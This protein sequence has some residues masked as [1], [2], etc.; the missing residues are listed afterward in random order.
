MSL[1]TILATA[2]LTTTGFHIKA[3]GTTLGNSLIWD[4]GTNVGIGNT[5]TSYTLD[6]SGTGRFTSTLLVSGAATFS[7]TIGAGGTITIPSDVSGTSGYK[8]N[9]TS[10][11]AGS[12][13]WKIANDS[14]AY[15]DFVIQQSTTQSGSTYVNKFII[16]PSGN[17]GIGVTPSNGWVNGYA[18]EVG[19]VGNAVWGR[20]S[21]EFH[22]T[23]NY[24][25]SAS[26][27]SRLYASTAPASDYEQYNG[28]H[29]WY[30]APSGTINTAV[31]LT[32]R[33]TLANNGNVLIGTTT[34]FS[35]N[36]KLQVSGGDIRHYNNTQDAYFQHSGAMTV[37]N[38]GTLTLNVANGTLVFVTD[39][40]IGDSAIFYCTYASQT[41]IL[42][43][44]PNS[45]YAATDTAGRA[46]LYKTNNNTGV[47]IFKN[48]LGASRS[49]T[50][51]QMRNSD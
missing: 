3:T 38:G 30:T 48:N 43:A 14:S 10:A 7:S 21:N 27:T 49:F 26:T 22:L 18:L 41:V 28:I 39:N 51:F 50:I 36:S 23:N 34:D 33:M 15:G 4:N 42:I 32:P 45:H 9:Y 5:N 44:D 47:A 29:T 2:P 8:I 16:S 20:Y 12:R 6:V 40:N 19:F 11:D 13:S 25:F 46:C 1:N 35:A 31:T 24:Y 17:V 37:A